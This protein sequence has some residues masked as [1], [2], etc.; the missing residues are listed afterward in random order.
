MKIYD[1]INIAI[2]ATLSLFFCIPSKAAVTTLNFDDIPL[3]NATYSYLT[4]YQN[5]SFSGFY[6]INGKWI[7][8]QSSYYA[9]A[10]SKKNSIFNNHW[11]PAYFENENE[12]NF[13]SSYITKAFPSTEGIFTFDGYNGSNIT[14]SHTFSSLSGTPLYHE[15]QWFNIT[16]VVLNTG[17][18]VGQ[19]NII[20]MDNILLENVRKSNIIEPINPDP[21]IPEPSSTVIFLLAGSIVLGRRRRF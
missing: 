12:F 20:V 15:F 21:L 9:G 7:D 6:A 1:V 2:T 4:T 14:Y 13:I 19:G 18:S 10:V 5:M 3:S 8:D 16:K 17:S 11:A